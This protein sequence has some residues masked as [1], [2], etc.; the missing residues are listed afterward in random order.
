MPAPAPGAATFNDL[1]VARTEIVAAR[2]SAAPGLKSEIRTDPGGHV[3]HLN[4]DHAVGAADL[5]LCDANGSGGLTAFDDPS[6]GCRVTP[7]F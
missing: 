5:P 1:P 3:L 2:R 7:N 4:V 6:K